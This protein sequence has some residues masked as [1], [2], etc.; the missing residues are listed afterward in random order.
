MKD[1]QTKKK[2]TNLTN[3]PFYSVEEDSFITVHSAKFL[4]S[5]V[6]LRI[7]IILSDDLSQIHIYSTNKDST[8]HEYTIQNIDGVINMELWEPSNEEL[9]ILQKKYPKKPSR[10]MLVVL[11]MHS[12]TVWSLEQFS[13]V[14]RLK[15]FIPKTIRSIPNSIKILNDEIAHP[16]KSFSKFLVITTGKFYLYSW[17]HNKV[18]K[19]LNVRNWES[20]D[21]GKNYFDNSFLLTASPESQT[22]NLWS[23]DTQKRLK[24]IH[25]E[26]DS[27]IVCTRLLRLNQESVGLSKFVCLVSTTSVMIWNILGG[28]LVSINPISNGIEL[29]L[30]LKSI[31]IGQSNRHLSYKNKHKN[32][33]QPYIAFQ[34]KKLYSL[35]IGRAHV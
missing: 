27:P 12:I 13:Q 4:A 24:C 19:K 25:Y 8:N 2:I 6:G 15:R 22:L 23:L 26:E 21:L 29:E 20:F 31:L 11:S 9:S 28:K 3:S 10:S 14:F 16:K 17:I 1:L 34:D 35:Q 32:R 30:S 5:K 7:A 33:N 18:L